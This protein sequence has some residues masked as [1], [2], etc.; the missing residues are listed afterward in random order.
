MDDGCDHNFIFLQPVDDSVAVDDH[1]ANV[2]IVEFW[3]LM[4][5]AR[6]LCQHPGLIHNFLEDDCSVSGRV[7]GDA[8]GYAFDVTQGAA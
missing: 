2:L 8:F 1:F 7:G 4:P 6:K 3:N 5:G